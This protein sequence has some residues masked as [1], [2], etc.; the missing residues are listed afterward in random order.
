MDDAK[1]LKSAIIK[2]NSGI[3]QPFK[4]KMPLYYAIYLNAKKCVEE[5]S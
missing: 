1:A 5:K 2:Y 4:G 3:N